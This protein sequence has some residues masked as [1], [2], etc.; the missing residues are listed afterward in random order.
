MNNQSEVT[1]R[2]RFAP[3][4]TGYLHVGSARTA[5]FAWLYARRMQGVFILRIEDTDLE[6]S[7]EEAVEAILQSMSWLGLDCDQGPFY[8]TKNFARYAEVVQQLLDSGHAYRCTCSKER[9]QHLREEQ[10]RNKIKPRYDACCRE[11]NISADAADPFVV[12]FK[13]PQSGTISFVDQVH[14]EITVAND[15]L[16]DLVIMR[17]DGVPTYHLSVVVD[18]WDTK[19]THVIRG[20]D[21]INNT[22]RQIHLLQALGAPVPVYAH[23]PTIL[24]A[25]GKKLSKRHGAVS[26]LQYRDQGILPQ[27]L[28]NYLLRLG[29][30]HGD[31]EIFSFSEMQQLFNLQ[32]I[33]HSPAAFDEAKLLW[34][35]QHYLKLCSAAELLPLLQQALVAAGVSSESINSDSSADLYQVAQLQAERANTIIEMASLSVYFYKDPIAYDAKAQK[36]LKLPAIDILKSLHSSLATVNWHKQDLHSSI[37]DLAASL[38]IGMGKVA[39]PLRAALTGG[40]VSPSI[41]IT[42]QLIGREASLRRLSNAWQWIAESND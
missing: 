12:R 40:V 23:V 33:S 26:V 27:A 8:Q 17:S 31:Q 39:Q 16:D 28:R 7:T 29:W 42:C 19:I 10:Q 24:G 2:T 14:G 4:P 38:D 15:Q 37:K 30:S 22:P 18:D 11:K 20:D 41:D 5:L 25:D 35:N 6:R 36:Q 13:T 32:H 3:S 21:H 9:L 1:V 34:L